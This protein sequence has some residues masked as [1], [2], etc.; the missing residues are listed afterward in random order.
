LLLVP[1]TTPI[2]AQTTAPTPETRQMETRDER[3]DSGLW[4]SQGCGGARSTCAPTL[5]R[6]SGVGSKPDNIAKTAGGA[7]RLFLLCSANAPSGVLTMSIASHRDDHRE[8][9]GIQEHFCRATV[10]AFIILGLSNSIVQE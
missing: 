1:V 5:S 8:G 7:L 6:V 9:P 3:G 4:G 10:P 2:F